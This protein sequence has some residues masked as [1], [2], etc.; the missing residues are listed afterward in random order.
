M[1]AKK[2][3]LGLLVLLSLFSLSWAETTCEAKDCKVTIT[4]K[5]AFSGANDS[6]I[7]DA[8]NEIESVWNGQGQTYGDC[9]CPVSFNVETKKITDPAQVNCNP[10]PPGYH[11]IMVTDYNNNPPRNQTNMTGAT[12]YIGYMYGI[13]T[14]NGGNSQKGWWSSIMSRPVDSNKPEGEHY[15]DFAHEAGHM[16]GLEDCDGGLM[17]QTSGPNSDPTQ[18]N[19]NE[20]VEEI[21]GANACPDRCCC[22]NGKK[23]KGEECDPMLTP[24]GCGADEYCCP[25][26]CSCW[27]MICFPE[28]GEYMSQTECQANCGT[29]AMCSYNYK[30]GCWDCVGYNIIEEPPY[31][32]DKVQQIT[33]DAHTTRNAELD[34][35]RNLY[36]EGLLAF[37]TLGGFLGNERANIIIEG[38]NNYHAL[39]D[40][41]ELYELGGG[42]IDDPTVEIVTDVGTLEEIDQGVLSPLLAYKEGRIKIEGVG[43]FGGIKFWFAEFMVDNFVPEDAVGTLAPTE[44]AVE[45]E[46][47]PEEPEEG[48]KERQ[49]AVPAS[50][51]QFPE[52]I[53]DDTLE[54]EV[55]YYE[56]F[57]FSGDVV[58]TG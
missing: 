42:A 10:G 43:F 1:S 29:N 22:G 11:C 5:I 54:V 33:D 12:F 46:M 25:I 6:Y 32:D 8:K 51:E 55:E 3:F 17:C 49:D 18:D 44:E 30:T 56:E 39:T 13:A 52:H 48:I 50:G 37:P 26:C 24:S 16:M 53:P 45:E 58:Y 57:N 4:I 2:L 41:G 7:N 38:K 14:G 40:E 21:C 27:G 19:I 23:D 35:I 36:E 20:A 9:D 31:A 34:S 47:P 28:W 15:K